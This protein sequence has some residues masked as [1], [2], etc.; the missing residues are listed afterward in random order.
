MSA[1]T[2]RSPAAD[3]DRLL[4][5]IRAHI[6]AHGEIDARTLRDEFGSSRKFA[7]PVLERLDALGITRRIGDK[8]VPG[9]NY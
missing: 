1:T 5:A 3:Y 2:S 9:A 7:I 6:E 4:A 8:R